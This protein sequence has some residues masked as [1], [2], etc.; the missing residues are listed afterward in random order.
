MRNI[1]KRIL[2]V[3]AKLNRAGTE[4]MLMNFY[5]NIDRSKIQFDFAICTEEHCDFEDEVLSMGG[6]VIRYPRYKGFNHIQYK[7][8][9]KEFFASHE[10]YEVVHGHIGSTAAIYLSIAK[11]SGRYTIAHSHGTLEPLSIRSIIWRAYSYPTRFIADHFFGCSMSALETRYGMKMAHNSTR[12]E[13]LNNAIDSMR[14]IYNESERIE[15]RKELGI[16]S[17]T[18]VIGTIGRLASQKNPQMTLGIINELKNRKLPFKFIWVGVGSLK[19]EIENEIEKNNLTNDVL[20]LGLRNDIPRVLQGLD[21]FVFPSIWEGLGIVAI[22]AQAA[23]L[24]TLCSDQVPREVKVTSLCKFLQLNDLNAW[25]DEISNIYCD[26]SRDTYKRLNEYSN[27]VN[28][29]YDI[30]AVARWLQDFYLN[31]Q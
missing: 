8:W 3:I 4:S 15:V 6:R 19:G 18:F 9:W 16:S 10:E 17:S 7:K 24:P 27:I 11:R 1:P 28:A 21:M 25:C 13:V 29:N 2:H 12:A 5:R 26:V 31:I 14:F 20:M 23:G 30:G 22:E